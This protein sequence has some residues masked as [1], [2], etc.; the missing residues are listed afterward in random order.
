MLILKSK[1]P[2]K[3]SLRMAKKKS[4][5]LWSMDECHFQQHGSRVAMWIPPE[6]KDPKVLMAPTR[7]SIALFGAVNVNDGRLVTQFEEKF[8]ALTFESFL[9]NL[10][11]H[12]KKG[13]KIILILDNAKYHHAK[14]LKPLLRKNKR[15]LQLEFLP[16]YSPELNPIERVWKL[17]RKL[18][19]HNTHFEKLDILKLAVQRQHNCWVKSNETLRRL[20][21]IN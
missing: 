14:L 18:C 7:K 8:D 19:T 21:C 10:L 12:R 6:E 13:K 3:K 9:K 11:R 15:N 5:D 4:I 1:K 20:C 2:L 17:T 16:P